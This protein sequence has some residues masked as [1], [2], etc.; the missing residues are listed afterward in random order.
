MPARTVQVA[1]GWL[2]RKVRKMAQSTNVG[3]PA[4]P[5]G[6]DR[7]VGRFHQVLWWIGWAC[8]A[9][10]AVYFVNGLTRPDATVLVGVDPDAA[11]DVVNAFGDGRSM[12]GVSVIGQ[13]WAGDLAMSTRLVSRLGLVLLW[14]LMAAFFFVLARQRREYARFGPFWPVVASP[15]TT[16]LALIVVALGVL[17][18][19]GAWVASNAV[20]AHTTLPAGF[21]PYGGMAPELPIGAALYLAFVTLTR[22][23]WAG[24]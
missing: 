22:H 18:G 17:P 19:F 2:R 3:S 16:T 13:W 14:V 6:A 7:V 10:A 24:R 9:V 23:A 5:V 12:T 20:L 1:A 8:A 4:P 21:E 15:W 11:L